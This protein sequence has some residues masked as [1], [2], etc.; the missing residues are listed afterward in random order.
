MTFA[1]VS[2]S[3]L[4]LL[5]TSPPLS[6]FLHPPPLQLDALLQVEEGK[7]K[8]AFWVGRDN[9]KRKDSTKKI[10]SYCLDRRRK[11]VCLFCRRI[12]R[13]YGETGGQS[14]EWGGELRAGNS[15]SRQEK[16]EVLHMWTCENA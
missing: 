16:R 11:F 6:P 14:W 1:A 3:S 8:D 5:H 12:L 2:S 13:Q 9:E 4:G 10:Q 7:E 15:L